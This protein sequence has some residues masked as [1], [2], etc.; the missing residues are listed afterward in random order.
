MRWVSGRDVDVFDVTAWGRNRKTI[1]LEAFQMKLDGFA[2]E[3]FRFCHS[4]PG[5]D[6]PG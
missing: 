2:D 1:C 3:G 4:G 6:T 5:G